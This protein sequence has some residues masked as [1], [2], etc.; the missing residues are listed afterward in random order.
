MPTLKRL[1]GSPDGTTRR[2]NKKT[3]INNNNHNNSNDGDDHHTHQHNCCGGGIRTSRTTETKTPLIMKSHSVRTERNAAIEH[4]EDE[5]TYE[6]DNYHDD[7]DDDYR[8]TVMPSKSLEERLQLLTYKGGKTNNNYLG[9]DNNE[10]ID[11]EQKSKEEKY[12]NND[13]VV[14]LVDSE[15]RDIILPA[16]NY[17]CHGDEQRQQQEHDDDDDFRTTI[18]P[19]IS[20]PQQQH[21]YD[22]D[23]KYDGNADDFRTTI[24][25]AISISLEGKEKTKVREHCAETIATTYEHEQHGTLEKDDDDNDFRST[26]M[27]DSNFEDANE[28]IIISKAKKEN[29]VTIVH[30]NQIPSLFATTADNHHLGFEENQNDIGILDFDDHR[31]TISGLT[32]ATNYF[33]CAAFPVVSNNNYTNSDNTNTQTIVASSLSNSNGNTIAGTKKMEDFLKT[34]T[35]AIRLLLLSTVE[36][37]EEASTIVDESSVSGVKKAER[38]AREMEK[39][40]E[41]L[42]KGVHNSHDDIGGINGNINDN[43]DSR[44]FSTSQDEIVPVVRPPPTL[45]YDYRNRNLCRNLSPKSGEFLTDIRSVMHPVVGVG[46]INSNVKTTPTV[47]MMDM[48]QQQYRYKNNYDGDDYDDDDI[49]IHKSHECAYGS[50]CCSR[51]DL[52]RKRSSSLYQLQKK[53][54]GSFHSSHRNSSSNIN[55]NSNHS[56]SKRRTKKRRLPK[57]KSIFRTVFVSTALLLVLCCTTFLALWQ[58]NNPDQDFAIALGETVSRIHDPRKREEGM[59]LVATTA[60][61]TVSY[62]RAQ[63]MDVYVHFCAVAPLLVESIQ[64]TVAFLTNRTV[65]TVNTMYTQNA[66]LAEQA[67]ARVMEGIRDTTSLFII[68]VDQYS[69]YNASQAKSRTIDCLNTIGV[70]FSHQ[71]IKRTMEYCCSII[72]WNLANGSRFSISISGSVQAAGLYLKDRLEYTFTDRAAREQRIRDET[73]FRE[74]LAAAA[75]AAAKETTEQQ[76]GMLWTQSVIAGACAFAGSVATNFLWSVGTAAL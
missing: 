54:D 42:V 27:D 28:T 59:I 15:Q 31:S 76:Q 71:T 24:M 45:E 67:K 47:A 4:R 11:F 36:S 12:Y 17:C 52:F 48:E 40:T 46:D 44:E 23:Y 51:R 70:F 66:P 13:I 33:H 26:I 65:D 30:D 18:M 49:A 56:A 35:E 6:G 22:G 1:F 14:C 68:Q 61:A 20:I 73:K 34:E 8:T 2:H 72:L 39:A 25:P 7:D 64:D 50:S 37:N 21:K 60:R 62:V 32:E 53:F 3:A 29:A 41:L 43:D 63:I 58:W 5:N 55:S 75:A 57:P 16:T 10:V 74:L 9:L 69:P 19:A 38:M